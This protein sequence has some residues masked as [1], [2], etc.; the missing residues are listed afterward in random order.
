M[1]SEPSGIQWYLNGN[2]INGATSQYYTPVQ[3]GNYTLMY[4]DSNGCSSTSPVY[5]F[6][7]VNINQNNAEI[8]ACFYNTDQRKFNFTGI[9]PGTYQLQIYNQLGQVIV[10]DQI[11]LNQNYFEYSFAPSTG[12]YLINLNSISSSINLKA[13]VP[14]E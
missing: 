3:N 10:R 4:T 6:G 2:I 9:T 11:A 14:A 5:Y 1:S 7:T 13:F 12:V 8:P